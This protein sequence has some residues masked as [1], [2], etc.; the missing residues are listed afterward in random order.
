M[1][2][3]GHL[4]RIMRRE[5]QRRPEYEIRGMKWEQEVRERLSQRVKQ[6]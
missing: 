4:F 6:A 5:S 3:Y 2:W 1:G